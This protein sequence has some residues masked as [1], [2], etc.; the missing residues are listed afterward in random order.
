[1]TQFNA[2]KD[3]NPGDQPK[4]TLF[5]AD[6]SEYKYSIGYA[7]AD[8]NGTW[9]TYCNGRKDIGWNYNPDCRFETLEAALDDFKVAHQAGL[10]RWQAI[11]A[12]LRL[13]E[14]S[15]F[16]GDQD[17]QVRLSVIYRHGQNERAPA[18]EH[19]LPAG[20]VFAL[21]ELKDD[22]FQQFQFCD[23][24]F[25]KWEISPW[26][27]AYSLKHSTGGRPIATSKTLGQYP[28]RGRA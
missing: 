11:D 24:Y 3:F 2:K 28:K 15:E 19:T 17:L 8:E 16:T 25:L 7:S 10:E 6:R 12:Y 13:I 27:D 22:K 20:I 9:T 23:K 4:Y 5:L 18:T 26:S 14:P 1:M 21:L